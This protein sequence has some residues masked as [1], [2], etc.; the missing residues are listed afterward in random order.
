METFSLITENFP[1]SNCTK[2]HARAIRVRMKKWFHGG[3]DSEQALAHTDP[4]SAAL[5]DITT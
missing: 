3:K 4:V 5:G 1:V 2:A